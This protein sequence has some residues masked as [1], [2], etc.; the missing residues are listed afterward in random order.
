MTFSFL[1]WSYWSAFRP[2]HGQFLSIFCFL[3][4][5]VCLWLHSSQF[6]STFS[7]NFFILHTLY[8]FSFKLIVSQFLGLGA[9][10]GRHGAVF[11]SK[12]R[13]LTF[14]IDEATTYISRYISRIEKWLNGLHFHPL[15]HIMRGFADSF[16]DTDTALILDD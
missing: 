2:I 7:S 3:F 14:S 4:D 1:A 10:R 12:K 16:I 9:N 13:A 8:D 6:Y 15:I 5:I 11:K